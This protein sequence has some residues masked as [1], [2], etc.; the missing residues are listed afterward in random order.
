MYMK[1]WLNF[2]KP[3][4]VKLAKAGTVVVVSVPGLLGEDLHGLDFGRKLGWRK[5]GKALNYKAGTVPRARTL[6]LQV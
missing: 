1:D 5:E 3:G 2:C 6:K 4:C